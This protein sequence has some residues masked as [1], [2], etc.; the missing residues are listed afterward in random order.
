MLKRG[1][2]RIHLHKALHNNNRAPPPP[3]ALHRA[4]FRPY[5]FTLSLLEYSDST[6]D[7][8]HADRDYM[9]I[10]SHQICA[11]IQ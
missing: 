2:L 11:Q 8:I 7:I 5:S 1:L 6:V 9:G 10:L 3:L 4:F